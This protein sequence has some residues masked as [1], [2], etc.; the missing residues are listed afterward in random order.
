MRVLLLEDAKIDSLEAMEIIDIGFDND[1]TSVKG[2]QG[3]YDRF[4]TTVIAGLYMIDTDGTYLYIKDVSKTE[5]NSICREIT[6]TG[7][8]DLSKFGE[9]E[10][11]DDTEF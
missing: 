1:I 10:Y 2:P 11:L 7:F 3:N 8:F 5:C 6:K 4:E 9:Y